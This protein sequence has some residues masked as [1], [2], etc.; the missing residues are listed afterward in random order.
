MAQP[1]VLEGAGA[2]ESVAKNTIV[3]AAKQGK[4]IEFWAPDRR[5]NCLEDHTGL[6]AATDKK[7]FDAAANYYFKG[8]PVNG[9]RFAGFTN[10][11][12]NIGKYGWSRTSA[13]NRRPEDQYAIMKADVP[14]Q[15][16]RKRGRCC[17]AGIP[18]VDSS[19]DTRRMGLRRQPGDHRRRRVQPVRGLFRPRHRHHLRPH[20]DVQLAQPAAGH[21]GHGADAR[22]SQ[23]A[24]PGRRP[25]VRPDRLGAAR[26]RCRR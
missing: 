7:S 23:G 16:T 22:H 17:A 6:T 9:K 18:W 11:L 13:S 12:D 24:R 15:Q 25:A 10:N 5:S 2:F 8:K 21:Q 4:R 14:D 3:K 26:W 19:P 1:G 20:R